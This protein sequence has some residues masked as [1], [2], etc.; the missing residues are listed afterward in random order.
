MEKRHDSKE[1]G[2]SMK[3]EN[4][5]SDALSLQPKVFA[6]CALKGKCAPTYDLCAQALAHSYTFPERGIFP[7]LHR[8][9]SPSFHPSQ[10]KYLMI[11]R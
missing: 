7:Y 4:L 8:N 11:P 1:G 9:S 10:E 2:K 5:R 3:S 6:G